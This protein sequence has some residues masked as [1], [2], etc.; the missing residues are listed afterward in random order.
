MFAALISYYTSMLAAQISSSNQILFWDIDGTLLRTKREGRKSI[1]LD[2]AREIEPSIP[3]FAKNLDGLT[4]FEIISQLLSGT[5]SSGF[6]SRVKAAL[7]SLDQLSLSDSKSASTELMPGINEALSAVSV[8]G[9][10]NGILTGNTQVRGTLKLSGAG[11]Q[12]HFS[13]NCINFCEYGED[14]SLILNR[15]LEANPKAKVLGIVGDSLSDIEAGKKFQIPVISVATGKYSYLELAGF[16]PE[17][18]LTNLEFEF[19]RFTELVKS[20]L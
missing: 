8:L 12:K 13:Q 16:N 19:S 18:T 1:H 3:E 9:V 15:F 7:F 4:D 10:T 20:L 2:A 6:A 17:R 11:L 14:R 5:V